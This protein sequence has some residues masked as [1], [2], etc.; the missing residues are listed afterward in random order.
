M[1]DI[2]LLGCGGMIPLPER[3]LTSLLLR[4]NGHMLLIDCGDGNQIPVRMAGWG[5]KH[6]DTLLLTHYHADHIS[7]LPGFLLTLGN[8][9]RTEP[10]T[11]VGPKGLNKIMEGVRI[12]A[13]DISFNI[14]LI[15][16]SIDAPSIITS[17]EFRIRS[18]P[19]DHT[20]PCLAYSVEIDR[21]PHFNEDKAHH[22]QV[23]VEAWQK[24]HKGNIVE[25]KGVTYKPKMVLD[26]PRK[27]LKVCYT[28]DSRPTK[29]FVDLA[30][31]ADLM[32]CE[33]MYG[34][35]EKIVKAEQNKHMMF[36]EAATMAKLAGVKRLW[37]TH[38]SPSLHEPRLYL[39]ETQAIFKHTELGENLKK[40][41]LNFED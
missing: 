13:P 29:G 7:G 30:Q 24:L 2:C 20:D 22:N 28:T 39:N 8:S 33:G 18:V 15:E 38:F 1:L 40:A 21:L 3:W 26:Y 31:N 27:G 11:I 19:M 14:E 35:P 34:D 32:V 10:L 9:M 12:I 16:L 4:Y 41:V 23:P 36:S 5:Y 6:I 25:Y 17:G 37:L